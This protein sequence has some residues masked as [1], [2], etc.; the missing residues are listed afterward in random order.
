MGIKYDENTKLWTNPDNKQLNIVNVSNSDWIWV[1]L[2]EHGSKIAQ[3]LFITI[4]LKLLLNKINQF[5]Q[6]SNDTGAQ[7]TFSELRLKAIRAAQNLQA[8][9]FRPHQNFCFMSIHNENLLPI[10]LASIGLACPIVPLY[11]LLSTDEIVRILTKI[12]SPIIFCDANLYNELNDALNKL[13]FKMK[14]FLL[15]DV[16][17]DGV[18]SVVNLF[19]ETGHENSFV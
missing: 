17:F 3:V 11:P 2:K 5:L 1:K 14:V 15:D 18:E 19:R 8:I 16:R 6:I 12:K 10:V 7:M 4:K 9:G 13:Q